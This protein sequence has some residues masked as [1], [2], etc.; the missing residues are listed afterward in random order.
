MKN[1]PKPGSIPQNNEV[2][3]FSSEE[4]F[5]LFD[6]MLEGCQVIGFDWRYIYLNR[7][8]EIHNRRPN[9]ELIGFCYQ[10]TWPGIEETDVYK[11]IKQTLDERVANS[12][13][14]RFLFPDGSEGWFELSIQPVPEGVFILSLDISERKKAESALIKSEEK[15]RLISDSSEEWIYWRAPDG[16]LNYVSPACEKITGYSPVEF[17]NQPELSNWIVFETDK[18]KVNQHTH[19]TKLNDSALN[20]EFRIVTKSGDIRWIS[21]SCSPILNSNGE[22]L[23][24]RGTNRDITESKLREEQLFESEFRF[25]KLYENGPFGMVMADREFR[26]KK[27]NSVFCNILGYNEKELQ[28]LTFKDVTHPDDLKKDLVNVQKLINKEIDVY[29]TEKRYIRKDGQVI[30][31]SLTVSATYDTEGQFLYNLGIIEDVTHRKLAEEALRERE[32]KLSTILNLLPV[33]IS[34]LDQ[35][36]KIVYENPALENILGITLEGMQRGDYR[37]R[38]YLRSDGSPKPAEE[39]ASSRVF[40]EKTAQHNFVTGIVREDGNTIWTNVSAVPVD[41]PD[42]KVVLVTADITNLKRTEDALKKSKQLLS[43]TESIG[44]VGGWEFNIDTKQQTWTDEVFRIHEVNFDFNPNVDNGIVFYTPESQPIIEKAIQQVIELGEPFDLELEIITAKG[45]LR[46]VHSIGKADLENRRIYGFF[47]DITERKQAEEVLREREYLLS[48][49]Q[50]AAHIGTWS[51]KVGDTTTYWSDETYRIYGLSP[52]MGSP[53]FEFFFEIIHPEDRYKMREW[54][55]AV[56]AGLHPS[57]V[58]FRVLRPDGIYRIIRT[59]GDIVETMDG[60]PS[61]IAGT[62]YD[63]TES[64]LAEED[65]K[66]SKQ[67][68]AETESIGKV[69]GWEFNIDTL[70]TTWTDEVYRIHE[71][72]FDFYHNVSKGINFY[73]D[74]SKPKIEKAVQRIIEYGEPFDLELEIITAKGN[75]KKVHTIGKPDMEN[76]RV[77]GF[78]QDITERKSVEE[79]LQKSENEFRLLAE[80][81]PQIVWVTQPDGSNIY[82]NQQWVDYTG[83]T[84][85]ESYGSGW[86][87]P[88]HPDEKQW[89]WDNWQ[90]ASKNNEVYSLECRL[91]RFDGEYKWWLI[92]GTSIMDSK[93]DIVK[94]FGTCTDINDLKQAEFEVQENKRKLDAAFSSMTDAI[95]ITDTDGQFIEFNEALAKYLRFRRKEDCAKSFAEYSKLIE[96]YRLNGELVPFDQWAVPRALRGEIVKNEEFKLRR[97]DT[98]ETWFGSYSFV[99]IRNNEGKITGSVVTARDITEQ[100]LIAEKI[101]EKD[102]EFNKLS[103]NVPDLIYQF[104]RKI[105]GNYC[106]P[107]ASKGIWNIF[108]CTPEE[109]K[110]D[111]TPIGRVIHPDDAERVINDIEYSAQHLTYFTCEFRVQIPGREIQWIYS[112]STPEQLP[113]GSITWYGFNTDITQQKRAEEILKFSEERYRNIFE[114]SV[115][116]IYRTTPERKIIMANPTLIKMLGFDSFEDLAKRDLE[117]EGFD[118]NKTRTKF[119]KEIEKNKRILGL[120]SVW[121][122]KDGQPVIVNENARA[123]YDSEGKV[124]YYEGTIEDITVRKKMENT[125]RE[126][127]EKFRKAFLT[128]PDAITINRF[129]NGLYVSVNEGFMQIFGYTEEE[130]LGKTSLEINL[131]FNPDDRN[132]FVK[133]L[134]RKGFVE[135]LETKFCTKNGDLKDTLMSS[136]IIELDN[137]PHILS[138]TK[139]ITL[140]KQIEEALK[141]N[142]ALLREVGRIARV[143]GW[144][145]DLTTN[146]SSWTEEVARIHDLDPKTPASVALSKNYYSESSKPVIERAFNN[147]IK[148]AKPYD[149]ELQIVSATGNE[150]WIRTI[151]HPVIIN[152]KV[153]KIQGSFQDITELK[154]IE[155]ALRESE[156]KFRGLME[157]IPLPVVYSNNKGE[158]IFGN[159]RFIQVFGYTPAELPTINEWWELAY[160]DIEYRQQVMQSWG[161]A[162]KKAAETG[163]DIE[164]DEYQITCKDGNVRTIIISGILI[165]ENLLATFID[166]TDRKKAEDEVRKLNETLEQRV[167]DRT[168][169][170]KEANQELEAFS[171]SVSHDLRAPLRHINGFIDLLTNNY[172]EQLPEKGLHYLDVIVNSTRQ[173]GSLIDDLL[174]FSRTGR[175]E[176]QMVN[177]DMNE[178]L[179]EVIVLAKNDSQ[180][181]NIVWKIAKMPIITGDSA[182]LRM[183][184]YNLLNN[185]IKFTKAKDPAIIEIGFKEAEKEYIF[186]VRDNGAGFDMKYAHKLFGVFQRLHSKRE[187]DGTGIGLANVRRIILRHGGRTWAESQVDKGAVFYFTLSKFKEE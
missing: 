50:R 115:I 143:G 70:E 49:S 12:L 42:W 140:R 2:R 152:N 3:F 116:G 138:T 76:R 154:N 46:S 62:A 187:F 151:G 30:W 96:I 90:Y 65:L 88:F 58:E 98:G 74:E 59:E 183:V 6:Y 127:E 10:D 181:R 27:T 169:Q 101:R 155:L 147:A 68:L 97:K 25:N 45:N 175:Q 5:H 73:T 66:K 21:H 110:D 29:K 53:D 63:I 184:W 67:L 142:E 161:L 119:R 22:N 92:R 44:K 166:I 112:K 107:I 17:V 103:A 99:P 60:I 85:E 23:G 13:E 108:G 105:D 77:Y 111:F 121:K 144:E 124:I 33:G 54:P 47:Q 38:K 149:L 41:F 20:L 179:Q 28:N 148:K 79:A 39:F 156:E 32:N 24:R 135:N 167:E 52:E 125:L 64:K 19:N 146:V 82:L 182:L 164:S 173:M 40:R 102:R 4:R 36:K 69:G 35:D 91:K 81:M 120:E 71:V 186:F 51:W 80:S 7:S 159:D 104:T 11:L 132:Q 171:Y 160:P 133:E 86:I 150:K 78:F 145:Y 136:V 153:V 106:V 117:K 174:Q 158:V 87:Q 84:L 83:L 128:N 139:D 176:M 178:V 109:V 114:S 134:G 137:V 57:P 172:T 8:A 118:G 130:V 165:N 1:Q 14:N 122:T 126:S 162:V 123:F 177:L 9:A 185:A 55:K 170:L 15:Y 48:S 94:W 95:F 100:K 56:I 61:R 75:L 157:S 43:E 131:W 72:D 113:D 129:D 18:E 37:E 16:N 31:G 180:D 93:G 26:F 163:S 34:I 141:Y 168:L 89:V